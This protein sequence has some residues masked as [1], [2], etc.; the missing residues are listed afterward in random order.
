MAERENFDKYGDLSEDELNTKNNKTVYARNDVMTT[1]IKHCNSEKK[2]DWKIDAFR[3]KKMISESEIPEC[4]EREVKSKREN[5]FVN[6]K[7]LE[8]YSVKIYEID[9]YFYE[10]YEEKIQANKNGG[11]YTLFSNDIYSIEYFLVVEV[12][13]NDYPDKDL[14]FEKKKTRSSRRKPWL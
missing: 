1:V 4:P 11:K 3:K 9:S 7:T 14:I 13:E 8:E 5:I 2:G 12:D 6:E 10:H